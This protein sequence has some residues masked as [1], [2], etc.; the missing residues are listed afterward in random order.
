MQSADEQAK[1]SQQQKD[2]DVQMYQ[3][4]LVDPNTSPEQR[5]RAADKIT[6]LRGLDKKESPVGKLAD[7]LNQ[8]GTHVKAAQNGAQPQ[9]GQTAQPAQPDPSAHLQGGGTN[10][11]AGPTPLQEGFAK[12]NLPKLAHG[13]G[14]VL[15]GVDYA[16]TGARPETLPPLDTS[17]FPTQGQI[18]QQRLDTMI[19]ERDKLM[20]SGWSKEEADAFMFGKY[21]NQQRNY[22]RK[23][24]TALASSINQPDQMLYDGS[25]LT[26][27]QG[28]LAQ[29]INPNAKYYPM[30]DTVSNQVR[31]YPED[32]RDL[33][34]TIGNLKYRVD[35]YTGDFYDSQNRVAGNVADTG[36]VNPG[37]STTS[38][39]FFLKDGNLV[40]LPAT[41][42][43]TPVTS[44]R[45][46]APQSLPPVVPPAS[47]AGGA[48]TP[49]APAPGKGGAAA[50]GGKKTPPKSLPGHPGEP[51]GM[52][53]YGTGFLSPGS[54]MQLMNRATP[55]NV[56]KQ[57]LENFAQPDVLNVLKNPDAA[58]KVGTYLQL[59]N[60][61]LKESGRSSDDPTTW[62]GFVKWSTGMVPAALKQQ[63]GTVQDEFNNLSPDEKKLVVAYYNLIGMWA[64]MRRAVGMSAAKWSFGNL[65]QELPF[66]IGKADYKSAVDSINYLQTEYQQIVNNPMTVQPLN[67]PDLGTTPPSSGGLSPAAQEYLKKHSVSQ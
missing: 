20:K 54:G 9:G 29:G 19:S 64:G 63:V 34:I 39:K 24:S 6:Q 40:S 37:A 14:H 35:P 12:K 18:E 66:G 3:Q 8:V 49:P 16:L 11:P 33:Y 28:K 56:A 27:S 22:L 17:V 42:T 25:P 23:G 26:D 2:E 5:K 44:N 67:L 47:Q 65:S 10:Q 45:P 21:P 13:L 41:T 61:L 51:R 53:T 32:V 7:F 15:Q 58:K 46:N 55:I 52:K 36:P 4:V 48:S 59:N 50:K 30:I 1:R 31:W 62:S 43:R 60:Q 38:P 57:G